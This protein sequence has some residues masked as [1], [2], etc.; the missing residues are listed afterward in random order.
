[1][2]TTTQHPA[3]PDY[4]PAYPY[5]RVLPRDLFNEAKLLKCLGLLALHVHE[6]QFPGFA[7]EMNDD[8]AEEGFKTALCDE[9]LFVANL[10]ITKHE[11][12]VFFVSP[13]NSR[14]AFPLQFESAPFSFS[15]VFTDS[16]EYTP[17]FLE[18]ATR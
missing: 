13:Y 15:E 17:E 9:G 1:M 7:V 18:F 4:L 8:E 12:P 16:G 6:G 11:A 5:A 10:H 14:A 3:Q 2:H